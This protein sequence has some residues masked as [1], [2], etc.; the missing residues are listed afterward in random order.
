[1]S[2]NVGTCVLRLEDANQDTIIYNLYNHHLYCYDI[3]SRGIKPHLN[4]F[5][6]HLSWYM[7]YVVVSEL[8]NCYSFHWNPKYPAL[9]KHDNIEHYDITEFT[10]AFT[11]LPIKKSKIERSSLAFS[12][13]K[14][15]EFNL[16]NIY[17]MQRMWSS[18]LRSWN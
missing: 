16:I 7:S 13:L 12:V 9:I 4:K 14:K 1:M 5:N 11:R 3:Q 6:S 2:C 15:T 17:K 8:F 18:G 10:N